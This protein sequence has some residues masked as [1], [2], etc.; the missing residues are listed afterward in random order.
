MAPTNVTLYEAVLYPPREVCSRSPI[1]RRQGRT[2]APALQSYLSD[3]SL[4]SVLPSHNSQQSTGLLRPRSLCFVKDF[5]SAPFETVKVSDSICEHGDDVDLEFVFVVY[6]RMQFRVA[7]EEQM[8]KYTYKDEETREANRQLARRDRQA[9]STGASMRHDELGR[10]PS[11]STLNVFDT[12]TAW[13]E[14]RATATIFTGFATLFEQP[15]P[16]SL[17]SDLWPWTRLQQS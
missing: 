6:T 7:T 14:Q 3:I 17:P 9:P 13:R 1:P 12:T 2:A 10:G 8:A 5:D 11:G 4:G 15:T 16:W